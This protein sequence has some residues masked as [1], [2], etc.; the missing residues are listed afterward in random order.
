MLIMVNLD[1]KCLYQTLLQ[2]IPSNYHDYPTEKNIHDS[3]CVHRHE[4]QCCGV[5][6]FPSISHLTT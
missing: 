6:V 5:R 3:S 1:S 4:L 2:K